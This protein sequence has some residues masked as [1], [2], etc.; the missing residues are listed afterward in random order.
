MDLDISKSL[1]IIKD[2]K[3]LETP[4]FDGNENSFRYIIWNLYHRVYEASKSYTILFE[5]KKYYDS[6]IIAGHILET[7]A[8]LSYIK[9]NPTIDLCREKY[10]KYLA[11][12]A[13]GRLKATLEMTDNLET[14]IS[15]QNFVN[16][17]KIFYPVAINIIKKKEQAK[18][19]HEEAIKQILFAN[20]GK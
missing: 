1:Q 17:L 10:N 18:E 7:C 15:W 14:D 6:F 4:T 13:L 3:P 8:T 2:F 9:D 5:N 19:K 11:S 12:S 16:L 20:K